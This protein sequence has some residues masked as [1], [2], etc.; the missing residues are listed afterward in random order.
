LAAITEGVVLQTGR[1]KIKSKMA[2]DKGDLAI[3]LVLL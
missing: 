1:L 3:S 2:I